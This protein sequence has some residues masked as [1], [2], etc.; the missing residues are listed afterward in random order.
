M[1][2]AC[3]ISF[4]CFFGSYMRIP[5]VPLFATSLGADSVQVGLINSAFMLMAGALS[6]PS[7]LI[8]DR[9]G[10]RRPLMAGLILLAGS[11]F[12]L[13]WSSSP[14]Q[15][16]G[17][18]L[19]FGV[20]LSAF[21]PTLMSYVADVTPPELLGQAY[22][23]YTMALYGGM[24]LGPAAGG[25]LGSALGLRPVFLVAGGLILVMFFVALIFLPEPPAG[26]GGTAPR[27][28]I[29]PALLGLMGNRPFIA[30]LVATIG[31]C[32]GFGMFVT[33]MPLYIR[34]QGLQPQ[35]VGLVFAAQALANALSRLPSG[36]L[37]DRLAD[38]SILVVW[39]LAVFALALAAFGLCHA[40]APLMAVAAVMGVSM[41]I[42]FTAVGALIAQV[43]P[44]QLRG[45]AMGCYNTCIYLGMM[46]CAAGMGPVI[47]EKGFRAGFFLNGA[48]GAVVLLLFLSLYRR[49]PAIE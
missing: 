19:L 42:A 45:L 22:G 16:A 47:R 17:I 7:G 31:T 15:M 35:H 12:L 14:L 32:F 5:I 38:R 3:T 1:L 23:W 10:R 34:S 43:V 39:G 11:S 40:V 37:A 25:F 33:F 29:R 24:T 4:V 46:L 6:I 21:S 8:S 20:G 44:R 49:Q 26:H 18:Y 48:V 41:G 36:R 13:Y 28:A 27:P 2:I 30:C 9:L